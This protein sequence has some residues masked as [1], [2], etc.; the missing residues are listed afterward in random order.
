MNPHTGAVYP[1]L[2]AA[3][4]AG[5]DRADIVE[6]EGEREAVGEAIEALR[7]RAR[8]MGHFDPDKG[9]SAREIR[10]ELA[11]MQD[12]VIPVPTEDDR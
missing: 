4:E 11:R 9:I 8:S 12:D 3:L 2:N 6:I 1:D 10:R 5:E 7:D